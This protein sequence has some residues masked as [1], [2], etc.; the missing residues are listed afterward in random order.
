MR[1]IVVMPIAAALVL[2]ACSEIDVSSPSFAPAFSSG[3]STGGVAPT[4]ITGNIA[5]DGAAV[6]MSTDVNPGGLEWLGF[7]IDP[8]VSG[9][10]AGISFTLSSDGKYLSWSSGAGVEVTAVLIKGGNSNYLYGYNPPPFTSDAGLHS[11]LTNG[12]QVPEISHFVF[13]YTETAVE[14]GCTPGFWK[15][16][17][18]T[19]GDWAV[20]DYATGDLLKDVFDFPAVPAGIV[21]LG[22]KT[23]LQA[24]DFGGGSGVVGGAQILLRAAVAA[25][26]NAAHPGVDYP[27]TEEQ[28]IVQVNAALVKGGDTD[29]QW[30]TR[31][32]A[33]ATTLDNHNNAGCPLGAMPTH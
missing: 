8:P 6:C 32:L 33:L 3:T 28:V 12:G 9:S 10:E 20:A 29:A 27:L 11:P 19:T 2:G 26:L 7:K 22:S 21:S 25:V 1:R 13:C 4:E 18:I 14:E 31:M 23:M 16:R 17:G 15:N 30:R 5:G 24:L